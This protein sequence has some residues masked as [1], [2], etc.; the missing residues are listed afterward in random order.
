MERHSITLLL[1]FNVGD[2]KRFSPIQILDPQEIV[3]GNLP[4]L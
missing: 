2:F 1:T 3:A 4:T